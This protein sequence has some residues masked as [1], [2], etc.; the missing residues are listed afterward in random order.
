MLSLRHALGHHTTMVTWDHLVIT[1]LVMC[2][3]QSSL[4]G[5]L[6][7]LVSA[8]HYCK[9]AV[10]LHVP[11]VVVNSSD[12]GAKRVAATGL[13]ALS[14]GTFHFH[15]AYCFFQGLVSCQSGMR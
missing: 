14:C 5:C 12:P 2:S 9:A 3:D 6:T 8:H 1:T 11:D 7:A 4:H 15:F 10:A 13:N